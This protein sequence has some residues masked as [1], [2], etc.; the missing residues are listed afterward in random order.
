MNQLV[1]A[2]KYLLILMVTL[3]SCI[4][5]GIDTVIFISRRNSVTGS[6]SVLGLLVSATLLMGGLVWYVFSCRRKTQTKLV[7]VA[8]R[9]VD[10]EVS[11]FQGM[12]DSVEWSS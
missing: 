5:F 9:V 1:K 2:N 10:D 6:N 11:A 7:G 3:S 4:F 12:S 8:G